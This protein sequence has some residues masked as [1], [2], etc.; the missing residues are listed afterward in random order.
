MSLLLF[1]PQFPA[2]ANKESK[3]LRKDMPIL[4]NG[5]SSLSWG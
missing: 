3:G 5:A 4:R 2:I 1:Q